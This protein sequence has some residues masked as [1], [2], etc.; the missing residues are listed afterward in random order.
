[1]VGSVVIAYQTYN[2][3]IVSHSKL[4]LYKHRPGPHCFVEQETLASLLT[5][6]ALCGSRNRF[7]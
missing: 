2:Q 5:L 7:L 1:V 3:L 4:I 6:V